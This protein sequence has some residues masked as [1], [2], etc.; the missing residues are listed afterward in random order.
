MKQ[1]SNRQISL[2]MFNLYFAGKQ[3]GTKLSLN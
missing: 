1:A 2:I 3:K